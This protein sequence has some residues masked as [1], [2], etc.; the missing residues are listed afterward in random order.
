MTYS[1][2]IFKDLDGDLKRYGT[3]RSEWSGGENLLRV[4]PNPSSTHPTQPDPEQEPDSGIDELQEAQLR[5]IDHIISRARIQPGHRVL[6]IGSGW[7]ALALRIASTIPNTTIDTLTLSVH[8]QTLA[9][10][11]IRAAGIGADGI[12]YSER[13][14]VHLMDYR[15]MPEEWEGAFDRFISVEMIEA[16]GREYLEKYWEVVDWA[17]KKVGGVGV[18]QVITIPE[19]STCF[20]LCVRSFR[21]R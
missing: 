2:A 15:A 13:I 16:V 12:P 21:R 5:K 18:V 6:E 10:E 19:P 1:C 7:G 14:A 17:V 11:R 8:Q 9:R 4:A 20:S 3:S